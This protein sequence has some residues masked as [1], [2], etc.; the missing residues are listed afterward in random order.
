MAV[1]KAIAID[2]P[3]RLIPIPAVNPK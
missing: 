2:P 1:I 3:D